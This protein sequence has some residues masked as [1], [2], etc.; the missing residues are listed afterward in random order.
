MLAW[1]I[2]HFGS[3]TWFLIPGIQYVTVWTVIEARVQIPVVQ[4][5]NGDAL[6]NDYMVIVSARVNF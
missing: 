4:N 2:P 6:K 5:L 3:I 1:R